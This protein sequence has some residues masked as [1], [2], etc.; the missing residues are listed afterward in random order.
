MN[1]TSRNPLN[2][3]TYRGYSIELELDGTYS[4]YRFGYIS[5]KHTN[6]QQAKLDIDMRCKLR[7]PSAHPPQT[8]R[9][10]KMDKPH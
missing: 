3:I 7:G 2:T 1:H 4:V 9:E 10:M 6:H 5:G 8:Q